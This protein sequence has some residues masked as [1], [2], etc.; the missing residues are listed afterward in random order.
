MSTEESDPELSTS[1]RFSESPET[2]GEAVP[3]DQ[4]DGLEEDLAQSEEDAGGSE[5]L[6]GNDEAHVGGPGEGA[7]A[8]FPGIDLDSYTRGA[9]MGSDVTQAEIDWLY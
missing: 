6:T 8:E 2:S 4:P 9:W 7:D 1:T 5:Q 3:A